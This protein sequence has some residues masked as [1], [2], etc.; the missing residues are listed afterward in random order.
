ME[1]AH[2]RIAQ[3]GSLSADIRPG[4]FPE[5][6]KPQPRKQVSEK[7]ID[8]NRQLDRALELSYYA[9]RKNCFTKRTK[10]HVAKKGSGSHQFCSVAGSPAPVE[11]YREFAGRRGTGADGNVR[12]LVSSAEF[13]Q[14]TT[15]FSG[16]NCRGGR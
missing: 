5:P 7:T 6:A 1:A 4:I 8:L 11:R 14:G 12:V 13:G 10:W 3:S 15:P 2:R 9:A 16:Q